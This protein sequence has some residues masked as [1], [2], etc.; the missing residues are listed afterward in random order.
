MTSANTLY[1]TSLQ[2]LLEEIAREPDDRS[3]DRLA[4]LVALIRPHGREGVAAAESRFRTLLRLLASRP[5]LAAALAG[6]LKAVLVARMHRTLY[7]ESGVLANQGFF[8]GL[9]SRV[10]GRMLPPAINDD[11]LRDLFSEVFDDTDDGDWMAAIPRED[12]ELLC[13]RLDLDGEAFAAARRQCRHELFE[14]MRMASHRLAAL[15]MEPALLRYMPALARHESPFLAQSD[16]V[17]ELIRRHADAGLPQ[18][19]DGHLEV[20][21]DQ[22]GSYVDTIQRRSREAGVGVNLVFL[23]ARIEQIAGRLRLLR[24]LALPDAADDRAALRTRAI[25]FFLRLVQQENRRNSLRDLF[26]GT[27]QLLARRVTEQASRSGEHYV[28]GSRSE[29]IAMFRA[30]AGAGVIIGTMALIKILISKL[31]LPPVWEAVA[32]SLDYGLGFVLIHILHLTIATKQ[33][34]M[35]AATLAAAL[36]GKQSRDARLDVLVELAAQVSRTQWISI[37]GNVSIGFIMALAIAMTAGQFLDW[38]P[39]DPIKGAH[40]LHDLHPWQ[41]LALVHAAIAGVFLF[42]SGLISGYYDNQSLYHRVPERLRR[43]KWL[44]RLIGEARLGRFADYIEHNLGALAGNFLF[45]CMLGSTPIIGNLL[46]LPLDIR[47]VA[48]ASANLAYGLEALAFDVA[49]PVVAT[50]AV[51]VVLIGLTNLTV[52][53]SLAMRV[54]LRS[55]GVQPDDTRGLSVKL[56][57]RF[58][59]RPRDFFWPPKE[60]PAGAAEATESGRQTDPPA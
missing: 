12:W 30:A 16:E 15:G 48:F 21:L 36:D 54:A 41:S 60:G 55:R 1:T 33:P 50:G 49:W 38:H 47:H 35:T 23:L 44:R 17:R 10:L 26:A 57:T 29:F 46:G 14:A 45:G 24:T 18:S 37:A 27:T 28:T 56:A 2:A 25:D 13:E 19:Y 53:F 11:F 43:V 8:S 32:Y 59:T 6:Y 51:G 22:C 31:G 3:G 20:L 58:L 9:V 34:A 39:V 42:L 40:L 7:S 4:R 52:S 5:D